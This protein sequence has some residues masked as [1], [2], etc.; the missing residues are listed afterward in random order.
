MFLSLTPL[1]F[2]LN[3][4]LVNTEELFLYNN[5]FTGVIPD[6]FGGLDLEEIQ[7]QDNALAGTIPPSLY[8]NTNL[9][10][11]RLD[12]NDLTGVISPAI[13]DLTSLV[14][15]RLSFN[16]FAGSIPS[17]FAALTNLGKSSTPVK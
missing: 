15:V 2:V 8:S 1:Y 10:K 11:I 7:L 3:Y 12:R 17:T 6:V 5:S 16:S 4:S 9:E 13:G 14:D